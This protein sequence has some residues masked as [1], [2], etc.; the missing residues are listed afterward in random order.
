MKK[1]K[2]LAIFSICIIS[3]F[4]LSQTA[5]AS[6]A[7]VNDDGIYSTD[8]AILTLKYASNIE[9]P[10]ESHF[11][12]ADIIHDGII[13]TDDAT[14]ILRIATGISVP[15]T[16]IYSNW[17][18][19]SAPTCTEDGVSSCFC[20]IC[21]EVFLGHIPKTDHNYADGVCV[22]CG[23]IAEKPFVTYKGFNFDFG[24]SPSDVSRKLGNPQD[25]LS[26]YNTSLSKVV[27]Y[28][29]CDDYKNLGIFTFTANKLTQFYTN[30]SD[31]LVAHGDAIYTLDTSNPLDSS[32]IELSQDV[33]ITEYV[34]NL[35]ANGEYV[36]SYT[37]T[38][39]DSYT[40]ETYSGRSANE[41]L[42]F[43]LT[44][45][46]RA[47]NGK[48]ALEYCAVASEAAYKHSNDMAKR[49]YF[50]HYSPEGTDPGDRLTAEGINWLGYVENIAAGYSDAYNI[51]NGWYNSPGHRSNLLNTNHEYLGVGLARDYDS[52][53][54]YYG[55][56]NFYMN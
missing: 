8:D 31:N 21:D 17:E 52:D 50:D 51:T 29:Y 55:T 14:E 15:P 34:D 26:D 19:V 27:I 33:T 12:A 18:T 56:Q 28:V 54:R 53:Y 44:N 43:H 38:V 22:D 11:D 1:F 37:A 45:G 35:A 47:I 41:K 5:E 7:D 9:I 10:D 30:N 46:L 6:C 48:A 49:G 32:F 3:L 42:V 24:Y 36:Y 2:L 39:G 40:F 4:T 13:D 16:H 20:L 23:H 25:T